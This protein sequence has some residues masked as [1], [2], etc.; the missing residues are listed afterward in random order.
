M[1]ILCYYKT[2]I[3]YER[4]VNIKLIFPHTVVK[5]FHLTQSYNTI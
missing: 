3:K 1:I 2:M 4:K 5:L